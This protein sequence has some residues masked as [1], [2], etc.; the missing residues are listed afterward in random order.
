MKEHVRTFTSGKNK[1]RKKD[2][3][4]LALRSKY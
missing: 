1:M 4:V 2:F 3:L